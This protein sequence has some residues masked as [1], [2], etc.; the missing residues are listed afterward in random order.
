M[1]FDVEVITI[2]GV[3]ASLM[4]KGF[5]PAARHH[6]EQI[7]KELKKRNLT[8]FS[9]IVGIEPSELYFLKHDYLDLLPGRSAEIAEIT[10]KTWLLEEFL[11]RSLNFN[12]LRIAT[13]G[14]KILLHSH[15]HQKAEDLSDDGL[16]N[17]ANATVEFLKKAGYEIELT[18]AGCCGMAGTFGYEKEHF[19][20]SQQIGNLKLF[21]LI[22]KVG[23]DKLIA[24]TGAAC[25]MQI[26]QGTGVSAKHPVELAEM[27]LRMTISD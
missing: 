21:P 2:L 20:L 13:N 17:G 27:A 16:S 8:N 14:K 12:N 4:S 3:G 23:N 18:E 24:A 7:L 5:I 9:A 10:S 1:G 6:A 11:I 22:K 26:L 19:D 25:R 15:C